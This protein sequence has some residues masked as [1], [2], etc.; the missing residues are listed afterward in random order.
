LS[1]AGALSPAA[2]AARAIDTAGNAAASSGRK[3]SRP[4]SSGRSRGNSFD[5]RS[6][7]ASAYWIGKIMSFGAS[8]A[9]QLPSRH[10][11]SEWTIDWAWTTTPMRSL[12]TPKSQRAS[13][14][15]RP[16]LTSVA[17]STEIF[18]PIDQ[19]GCRKASSGVI[20]SKVAGSRSRKGPPEAVRTRRATSSG[21]PARSA[22]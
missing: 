20:A 15:S 16:L 6:G 21:A 12:G 11:T 2:S 14:S 8:W 19:V 7:K 10:S 3:S 1:T 4:S 13:I 18:A 22:W 17:E 5:Q 9:I